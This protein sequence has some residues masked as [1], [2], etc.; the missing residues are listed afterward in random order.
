MSHCKLAQAQLN[1][2]EIHPGTVPA[3]ASATWGKALEE[4]CHPQ[5]GGLASGLRRCFN[6]TMLILSP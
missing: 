1:A 3:V 5:P 2:A 4:G 6:S